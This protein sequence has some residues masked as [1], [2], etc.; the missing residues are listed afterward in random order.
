VPFLA[1]PRPP[2]SF[3]SPFLSD[4]NSHPIH[5]STPP[6][7]SRRRW[8][9]RPRNSIVRSP[10]LCFKIKKRR[11]YMYRGEIRRTRIH[12]NVQYT[13]FSSCLKSGPRVKELK[14]CA[15]NIIFLFL[16]PPIDLLL[17]I[18]AG[19]VQLIS[20]SELKPSS[21][22]CQRPLQLQPLWLLCNMAW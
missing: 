17:R 20:E 11:G 2:F 5:H 16:I 6:L 13:R 14:V 4:S 19:F 10:F 9:W 12:A 1:W 8:S 21:S 15:T 18:G 7:L 3:V 22:D